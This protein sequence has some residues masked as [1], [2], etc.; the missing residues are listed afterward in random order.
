[1][2]EAL[3]SFRFGGPDVSLIP[4][5]NAVSRAFCESL[6]IQPLYSPRPTR[7]FRSASSKTAVA[8]NGSVIQEI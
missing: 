8:F 5:S 1:M 6:C 2:T 7:A 3:Q 4:L